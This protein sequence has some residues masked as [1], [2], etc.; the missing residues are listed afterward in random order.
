MPDSGRRVRRDSEPASD[1]RCWQATE[2]TM[3]VKQPP[4][5]VS[6]A[7]S[8]RPASATLNAEASEH[9]ASGAVRN[10]RVR[11]LLVLAALTLLA[12]VALALTIVLATLAV[13][14]ADPAPP[15]PT[16]PMQFGPSIG[17]A[18]PY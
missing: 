12:A 1:D 3:Q 15:P 4:H 17:H 18:R 10:G 6:A 16:S 2:D 5:T 8:P 9:P 11:H 14:P 7:Q 13:A